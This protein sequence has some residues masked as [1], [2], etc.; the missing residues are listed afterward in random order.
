MVHYY[1][2]IELC[3]L[4]NLMLWIIVKQH[5]VDL[6]FDGKFKVYYGFLQSSCIYLYHC[7]TAKVSFEYVLNL[8][9]RQIDAFM[10]AVN[11]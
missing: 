9:W 2:E 11:W 6:Y 10:A 7:L 8:L 3:Y 1:L 5:I 4:K